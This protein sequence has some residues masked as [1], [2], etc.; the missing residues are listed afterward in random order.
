MGQSRPLD[1]VQVPLLPATTMQC[2]SA[3]VALLLATPNQRVLLL[4]HP[5]SAGRCPDAA[6]GASKG[7]RPGFSESVRP[8]DASRRKLA[9]RAADQHRDGM[10]IVRATRFTLRICVRVRWL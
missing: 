9:A 4:H 8:A 10:Q 6:R 2:A 1:R 3:L 7:P 5:L